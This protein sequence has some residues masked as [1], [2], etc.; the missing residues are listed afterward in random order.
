MI[1][2]V[3]TFLV[4][5]SIWQL[6]SIVVGLRLRYKLGRKAAGAFSGVVPNGNILARET[7]ELPPASPGY[8]TVPFTVPEEATRI[9]ENAK[10]KRSL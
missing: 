6:F 1:Y 3:Y 4:V 5:I 10:R 8:D 2:L 7:N 9:L